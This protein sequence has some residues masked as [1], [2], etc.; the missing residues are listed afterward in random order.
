MRLAIFGANGDTSANASNGKVVKLPAK[1]FDIPKSSRINVMSEPTAVSG[2]R[3][4]VLTKMTPISKSQGIFLSILYDLSID[5]LR[6]IL[7]FY[8]DK[9][10]IFTQGLS[11]QVYTDRRSVF[12][13]NCMT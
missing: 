8:L 13:T 9:R 1:A 11:K 10:N 7:P 4:L 3:K 12:F 2:A 6:L 5:F